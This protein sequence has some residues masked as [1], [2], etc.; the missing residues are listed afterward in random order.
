MRPV[1]FA[2]SL[3]FTALLAYLTVLDFARNGV[4]ALGVLGA[5]IVIFFGIGFVGALRHPPR[6]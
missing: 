6:Q 3:V 4:T 2:I 1:V 5:L